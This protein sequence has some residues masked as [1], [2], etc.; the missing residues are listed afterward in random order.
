MPSKKEAQ[1]S[2]GGHRQG[3]RHSSPERVNTARA[4]E[5]HYNMALQ[6]VNAEDDLPASEFE[7]SCTDSPT[8]Q[9]L[10][11]E[12]YELAEGPAV[13]QQHVLLL[14][15]PKSSGSSL[16]GQRF[17]FE[18]HQHREINLRRENQP[19]IERGSLSQRSSQRRQSA[20]NAGK[21]STM[22]AIDKKHRYAYGLNKFGL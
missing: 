17:T 15:R 12:V 19:R 22:A 16:E 9:R 10:Q 21:Q 4:D 18:A 20:G 8:I 1:H 2:R 6:Q 7:F 14:Q 3:R 11:H 5:E 13:D